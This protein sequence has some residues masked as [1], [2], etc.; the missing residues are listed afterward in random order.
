MSISIK[1]TLSPDGKADPQD[2]LAVK[3]ALVRTG[4][5]EIPD[6]GLTPYPDKHLFN[7]IKSYQKSAGLK[8]DGIMKP[9]GETIRHLNE[10]D[11]D[12][13]EED[14]PDNRG[15]ILRCPE[16]G[17][18]HGGSKGDLCPDCDIKQ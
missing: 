6:Y 7:A 15:P 14:D 9:Q 3:K 1:Q 8:V 13:Y 10:E 18:P 12:D 17:A 11:D 4:H 5:Y 16:C 2:I